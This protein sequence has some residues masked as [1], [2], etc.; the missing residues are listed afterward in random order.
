MPY[1]FSKSQSSKPQSSSSSSSASSRPSLG[2]G[3]AEKAAKAIEER[4][5]TVDKQL[6][7]YGV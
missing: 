4:K 3:L 6:A 7:A 5:S 1:D 2:T